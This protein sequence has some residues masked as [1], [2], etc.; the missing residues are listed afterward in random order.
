MAKFDPEEPK[1]TKDQK[2]RYRDPSNASIGR[3]FGIKFTMVNLNMQVTKIAPC[4][5]EIKVDIPV[6]RLSRKIDE[7]YLQLGKTAKIAGFRKGKVPRNVLEIYYQQEVKNKAV[8]ETISD[9]YFDIT[10]AADWRP[11]GPPQISEVKLEKGYLRFQAIVE[12]WPE[13]KLGRYKGIELTRKE[14]KVDENDIEEQLKFLQQIRHSS[15]QK[16]GE[17]KQGEVLPLDDKFAQQMGKSSLK[18]LKEAIREDLLQIRKEEADRKLESDLFG[19]LL[20]N[21]ALTLPDSLIQRQKEILLENI[22][23]RLK[24]QGIKEKDINYRLK[25]LE[26]SIE[27]RAVKQLKLFFIL[28]EIARQEKIELSEQELDKKI[29]EIARG[30]KKGFTE[31]K[32]D[33]IRKGLIDR[34][35]K[36]L[37]ERKIVNFLIKEAKVN[38]ATI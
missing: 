11:I 16:R 34:F 37:K 7:L 22:Q 26:K 27:D 5:Q 1:A 24:Q 33:L 13:V 14:R 3:I 28:Q 12:I 2:V 30:L 29:D 19:E 38:E 8:E 15:Q 35:K 4:K 20:R 36:E 25:E 21:S 9:T 32:E 31:I 6:G 18:E 17:E 23:S 10:R